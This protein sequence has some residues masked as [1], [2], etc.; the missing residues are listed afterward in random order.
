MWMEA[1]RRNIREM[2]F[3]V[4]QDEKKLIVEINGKRYVIYSED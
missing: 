3:S 2:C 1:Q 4:E